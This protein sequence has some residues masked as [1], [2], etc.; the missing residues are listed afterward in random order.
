[1]N[2]PDPEELKSAAA[3]ALGLMTLGTQAI[4][5]KFG[6]G[7]AADNPALLAA[8][9]QAAALAFSTPAR[10]AVAAADDTENGAA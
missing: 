5:R 4:D 7:Y 8:F 9:M 2:H 3:V 1:M 6:E 10:P